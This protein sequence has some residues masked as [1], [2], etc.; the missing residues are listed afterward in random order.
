[1][2]FNLLHTLLR[3]QKSVFSFNEIFL[4][5]G[6]ADPK[7]IANR[8][9][10]YTQTGALYHIRRGLYAKDRDYNR[11]EVATK[12]ITPAYISFETVLRL[13][14]IIFQFYQQ[15]FVASTHTRS[16]VCDGQEY[17]FKTIKA[18]ILTHPKGIE[19]GDLY[20]IATAE[21]AFLDILYLYKDYHLDNPAPLNWERVYDI[22]PLYRSKRMEKTV[23]THYLAYK[24]SKK[25]ITL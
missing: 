22:L 12:I 17:T 4:L 19:I 5:S 15:I 23:D 6:E 9:H 21:R 2:K 24:E 25:D 20:S 14:G 8:L 10:Y 11:L 1:M 3:S 7:R 13:E 16:I 18:S